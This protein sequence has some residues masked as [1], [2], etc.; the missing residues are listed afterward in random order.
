VSSIN[1]SAKIYS[2]IVM[3]TVFLQICKFF[4]NQLLF[5]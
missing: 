1:S 3:L 5:I 4:D 2:K